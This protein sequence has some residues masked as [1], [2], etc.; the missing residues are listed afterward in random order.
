MTTRTLPRWVTRALAVILL[1]A[2][3]VLH[4]AGL[5][6]AGLRWHHVN[7]LGAISDLVTG[8]AAVGLNGPALWPQLAA[9]LGNPG[10]EQAVPAG[11]SGAVKGAAGQ[12]DQKP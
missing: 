8:A 7:V 3:Y 12:L 9:F 11:L 2:T 5:V 4:H 6:P 10:V 1:T